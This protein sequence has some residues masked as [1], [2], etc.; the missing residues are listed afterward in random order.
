M[1]YEPGGSW[2]L[3][4]HSLGS[5]TAQAQ[6]LHH[7]PATGPTRR[8][9]LGKED[10]EAPLL[11]LMAIGCPR[12]SWHTTASHAIL[13]DGCTDGKLRLGESSPGHDT[14]GF[15]VLFEPATIHESWD[16]GNTVASGS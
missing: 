1:I 8:G 15:W 3:A 14:C 2:R 10:G 12:G 7:H 16:G 4:P 9:L 6:A 11:V 13:G 5:G